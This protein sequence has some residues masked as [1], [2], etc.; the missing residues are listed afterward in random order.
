MGFYFEIR[1]KVRFHPW[2]QR[3]IYT[4]EGLRYARGSA[5]S[6]NIARRAPLV[7]GPAQGVAVCV[8][9][10]DEASALTEW[11]EY[12]SLAG[13]N[14]FFIYE[15]F[16]SDNF[17]EVLRPYIQNGLVTL[18]ADWPYVPV[19]PQAEE[20]CILRTL[21][22][23][24]WVGFMDMDEFLVIRDGSAIGEFLARFSD[25][26]ACGIHW[27]YFGTSGHKQRVAGSVIRN[28]TRRN[29]T[30]NRHLKVF[31]RP[32]EATHCRNPHSW[33]FRNFGNA[34]TEAGKPVY[35]SFV[36]KP[37]IRDAWIGHFHCKSEDEY[38]AKGLKKEACD[39]F[40]M[41][42]QRITEAHLRGNLADWNAVEDLSV[43]NYYR[44]RCEK[45]GVPPTL[46][47]TDGL[48]MPK[49]TEPPA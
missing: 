27:I 42:F 5:L 19:T 13:V 22:R 18:I 12:H 37:E 2:V 46:L 1:E 29:A 4:A 17:R 35:G 38:L 11:L 41:K 40:A 31:V 3:L 39:S 28:Y 24:E 10:K 21:N 33:H 8:R 7:P 16:S 45:N 25:R 23:F 9:I 43:Q 36:P 26:P 14:H 48:S 47:R 34:V 6:R 32:A 15:S 49:L 44:Q 30:P 20:D